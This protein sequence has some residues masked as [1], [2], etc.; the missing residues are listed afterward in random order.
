MI[1]GTW[2]YD[3]E[4]YGST[5]SIPD[6]LIFK[7]DSTYVNIYAGKNKVRTS[8]YYFSKDTLFEYNDSKANARPGVVLSFTPKRIKVQI[9][10]ST[11]DKK[12]FLVEQ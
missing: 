6:T 10:K 11:L 2:V 12:S 9:G 1:Q 5:K 7:S 4:F 8:N 3:L